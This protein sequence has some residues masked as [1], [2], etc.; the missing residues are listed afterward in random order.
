MN[1]E[2]LRVNGKRLRKSLE[3]MARIGATPGGGVSRLALSDEDRGARNLFRQWLQ[4]IDLEVTVDEMGNIFGRRQGRDHGLVAGHERALM[5]TRSPKGD[6]S[7]GSSGSWGC[8][9]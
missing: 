5:W 6:D 7:T 8:W 1:N 4:E 9:R 2:S 3:S